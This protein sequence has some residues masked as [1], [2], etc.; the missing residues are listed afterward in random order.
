M[1]ITSQANTRKFPALTETQRT[2]AIK[3]FQL[4]R[5]FLTTRVHLTEIALNHQL[6]VRTLRRWIQQYRLEGL[7]G[8]SKATRK[9]H[10]QRRS[11]TPELQHI[12]E[13]LAL[14]KPR[15]TI[16]NIKRETSRIS[17]ERNWTSPSYSTIKR[18]VQKLDP[19][20]ITLAH[21]GS[22]AYSEE[23]DLIYRHQASAPNEVWQSDHSL[24]PIYV[25]D[26][27]KKLVRP[28]LMIILDDYSRAVSGYSLSLASPNASQTSLTLRQA[29]WRKTDPG[30]H[31]CG[32][33]S[34]FY[35]DNGSDFTSQHLE[36]VA[37]DLKMELVFSWPGRPRGRGKIERFFRTVEQLL[38]PHLPGFAGENG[39][40]EGDYLTL[41]AFDA[42]FRA[43][44][45]TEYHQRVHEEIGQAPQARW[46]ASGFLPRMPDS[47]EQL[48]LLLLHVAKTRRVQEFIFR[49]NVILI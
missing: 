30:W 39:K 47:L 10:G 45:L 20:L 33:P 35:T 12:I 37:A 25:L 38:L 22:K 14:Q 32:I 40:T 41:S 43:W 9:D 42:C 16:A 26:E 46:E 4:I 29:I 13:G 2:Q 27:H 19:Q 23:F 49:G 6:S 15:R 21:E 36:Q 31:L 11:V 8:L 28:W 24:L 3:R 5:P 18:I 1:K 44:L 17:K 34:Q 7:A 48:D